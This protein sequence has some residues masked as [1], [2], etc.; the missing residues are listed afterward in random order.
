MVNVA[1]LFGQVICISERSIAAGSVILKCTGFVYLGCGCLCF[2]C[3]CCPFNVVRIDFQDWSADEVYIDDRQT[4][5]S[6]G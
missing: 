1:E 4:L 3:L 5:S 2:V 6:T